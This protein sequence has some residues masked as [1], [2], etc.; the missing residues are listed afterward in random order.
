MLHPGRL[1]AGIYKSLERKIIWTK[2]PWGHVQKL[3]FRGVSKPSKTNIDTKN[4]G[5]EEE[6]PK[7]KKCMKGLRCKL[8]SP[9]RNS[10][11][12]FAWSCCQDPSW[13]FYRCDVVQIWVATG[14][15]TPPKKLGR[16]ALGL[17]PRSCVDGLEDVSP[18]KHG[19][20]SG[21]LCQ[22]A[23]RNGPQPCTAKQH[24]NWAFDLHHTASENIPLKIEGFHWKKGDSYWKTHP[25]FGGERE[26]ICSDSKETHSKAWASRSISFNGFHLCTKTPKCF[27]FLVQNLG[28]N[29]QTSLH[30]KHSTLE[31]MFLLS[32]Q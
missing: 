25:F 31:P 28:K 11:A 26:S 30:H 20:I 21:G 2:P 18:S 6:N 3:I 14:V 22:N 23:R 16:N 1:T 13:T 8:T 19:V 4:D 27:T 15:L 12:Y 9:V 17:N 24:P 7:K 5:L 29:F 10:V 32:I